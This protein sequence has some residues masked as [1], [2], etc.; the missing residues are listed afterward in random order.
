MGLCKH[1]GNEKPKG[2]SRHFCSDDCQFDSKTQININTPK[3]NGSYCI[4]W[5]AG[6]GRGGYGQFLLRRDGE[7]IH[8]KSHR[9]SLARAL[10][11][12]IKPDMLALHACDRPCCVNPDHLREGTHKENMKDMYDR[13]RQNTK[14][15]NVKY[16]RDE[17][18]SIRFIEAGTD[19][20]LALKYGTHPGYIHRIRTNKVWKD[21]TR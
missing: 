18:Y 14:P 15:T 17:I 16:T 7:F 20:E 3:I 2:S 19:V 10:G 4:D 6:H 5:I 9:Y 13:G 11:R 1:C 21:I 8:W 12:D